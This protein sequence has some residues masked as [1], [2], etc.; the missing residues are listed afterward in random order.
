MYLPH[1]F[2][3]TRPE[4]LHRIMTEYPLGMLV[5]NGPH[6]LDANHLPFL[7]EPTTGTQGHLIAHVARANPLWTDIK[8]GDDVLVVFRGAEAYI[9]PNWYPS[10]HEAHRQVPTWNYQVV[11]VHGK[12][13]IHD[14]ERFVRSVVARLTRLHEADANPEAPWRMGDAPDDFITERLAAIVGIEIEI[15]RIEG[16]SKLNQNRE[17]RD[18]LGAIEALEQRGDT[19]LS[20]AMRSTLK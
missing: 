6:G 16:K 3:E 20:S 7:F 12:I 11:H 10:K 18:R 14:D 8:T 4:E 15:T 17:T 13:V 19:E 5:V 9:S 1:H 2:A